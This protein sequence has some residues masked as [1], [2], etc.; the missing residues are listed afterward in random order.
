MTNILFTFNV[1][2]SD[3]KSW[4]ILDN[5][6]TVIIFLRHIKVNNHVTSKYS[7]LWIKKLLNTNIFE[8]LLIFSK[9]IN[10]I[11]KIVPFQI[12]SIDKI[13]AI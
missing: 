11:Y 10:F 3:I 7:Y 1:Y 2:N 9:N 13:K 4:V 12:T 8:C 5:S 6:A